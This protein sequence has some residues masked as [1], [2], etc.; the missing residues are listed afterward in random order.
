MCSLGNTVLGLLTKQNKQTKNDAADNICQLSTCTHS[1][2]TMKAG[3]VGKLISTSWLEFNFSV[4]GTP[5]NVKHSVRTYGGR[6]GKQRGQ[7]GK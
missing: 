7:H 6:I 1:R 4:M 2:W 5:I 3:P